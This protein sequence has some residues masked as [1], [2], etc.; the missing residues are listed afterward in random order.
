M[1]RRGVAFAAL[2]LAAGISST[3]DAELDRRL[4]FDEPYRIPVSTAAAIL[5]AR[6]QGGRVV[7]IGTTTV[8]TLEYSAA[9]SGR[10]TPGSGEADIFIYPGFDFKV[11]G[12]ML[13]NF[14]LPGS[15]LRARMNACAVAGQ[16]D[17]SQALRPVSIHP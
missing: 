16:S 7:A 10:V 14:H 6:R 5:E 17:F 9:K 13:T 3:G 1:Q 8:R 4:P 11:V 2:S 12:A 15:T